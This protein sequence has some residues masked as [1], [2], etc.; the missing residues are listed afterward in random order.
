MIVLFIAIAGVMSIFEDTL[1]KTLS[2]IESVVNEGGTSNEL[3]GLITK[4]VQMKDQKG[5]INEDL[6]IHIIQNMSKKGYI[7]E[8]I[9]LSNIINNSDKDKLT[10]LY[11]ELIRL[12][13]FDE[14]WSFYNQGI[15]WGTGEMQH[16]YEHI[17]NCINV[18]CEKNKK[19]EAKFF[20]NKEIQWFEINVDSELTPECKKSRPKYYQEALFYKSTNV[21]TKLTKYINEY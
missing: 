21:K 2:K 10:N 11:N 8:A 16:K 15:S 17:K 20:L 3:E 14:A 9:G 5:T 19:Q 1:E 7:D 18:L 12:E 13:R 4:A 6:V